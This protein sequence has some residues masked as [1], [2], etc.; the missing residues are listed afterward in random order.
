V[1]QDRVSAEHPGQLSRNASTLQGIRNHKEAFF[2]K[3]V[4]GLERS[5]EPALIVIRS[6]HLHEGLEKLENYNTAL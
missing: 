2:Y 3:T 1:S 5:K 4:T 6:V